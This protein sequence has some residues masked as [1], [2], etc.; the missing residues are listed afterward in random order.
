MGQTKAPYA[1]RARPRFANAQE[2][3]AFK[4]ARN[5]G[6]PDYRPPRRRKPRRI[7]ISAR[8]W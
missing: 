2:E 4:N 3:A 6:G 8:C 7:S 1:G 5:Y